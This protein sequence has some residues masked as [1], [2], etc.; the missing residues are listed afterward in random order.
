MSF[1][2]ETLGETMYPF[3]LDPRKSHRRKKPWVF[4]EDLG[5]ACNKK[6]GF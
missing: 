1:N 4:T 5:M 6:V 3:K 2:G